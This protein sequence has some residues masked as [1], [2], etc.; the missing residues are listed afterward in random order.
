M[1]SRAHFKSH[2]LHPILIAFPIA[3]IV[4]CLVADAVGK[5]LH[6]PGL[7]V[8]GSYL[9]LGA[10]VTGLIAAVPGLIDYLTIIPPGSSGK[11][12]ATQHMIINVGALT[13]VAVGFAF[14]NW[15]TRI[16][17]WPTII[18]ELGA[19]ALVSWGGWL[20]GTLVYRNQI[21]VDHRYAHAG[22]WHE[23]DVTGAPGQTIAVEGAA[24]EMKA[25]QMRLLKWNGRRI[26]LARSEGD[27]FAAFD[28]HCTHRG[29]PLSDGVLICGTVQ[30]PWHGSQF[31]VTTGQVKAGPAEKAIG[32]YKAEVR[33]G[34][35]H[36]TL[37]VDR[38]GSSES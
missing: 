38:A 2:P 11:K 5:L 27:A 29:G 31:D 6:K 20:G 26:V 7:Q 30:C 34:K 37:P 15:H 17:G 4:G 18:L 14:R 33:D 3:F 19:V 36:V 13:L 35:V 9:S 21:A 16:P 22:K 12:R 28:D 25:G 1:R 24:N 10:I 32:S 8:T 23:Q